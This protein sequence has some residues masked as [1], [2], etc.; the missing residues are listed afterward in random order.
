MDEL[1]DNFRMGTRV[2]LALFIVFLS[3]VMCLGVSAY[4]Q[5]FTT[6]S[7]LVRAFTN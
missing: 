2:V 1:Q 3:M 5:G 4:T 7:S 6:F